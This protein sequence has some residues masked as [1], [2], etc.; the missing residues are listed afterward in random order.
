MLA[1]ANQ[2][3][4]HR[5]ETEHVPVTL[6]EVNRT[7]EEIEQVF[8]KYYAIIVGPSLTGLE[9][10]IIG[11]WMKPFEIPWLEPQAARSDAAT[12]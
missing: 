10:S 3:V 5:S 4:A 1:Y 8:R 9:P 11:D 7:L 6:G 2:L 12:A